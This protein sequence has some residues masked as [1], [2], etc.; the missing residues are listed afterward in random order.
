VTVRFWPSTSL[1]HTF[2]ITV[3]KKVREK[4]NLKAG[5]SVAFLENSLVPKYASPSTEL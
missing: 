2:Q 3:P 4:M 5:Q 1:A